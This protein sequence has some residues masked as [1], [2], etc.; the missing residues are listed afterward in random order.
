MFII[1]GLIIFGLDI[2]AILDCLASNRDFGKKIAWVIFIFLAP[3]IGMG[4]YY[5]FGKKK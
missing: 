1:L 5:L 2:M 3:I 4:I